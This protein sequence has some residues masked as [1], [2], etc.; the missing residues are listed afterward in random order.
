M[1]IWVSVPQGASSLTDSHFSDWQ[2]VFDFIESLDRDEDG[3]SYWRITVAGQ[4][5][6]DRLGGIH[7]VMWD[8]L[9]E[10]AYALKL[11]CGMTV[12][13]AVDRYPLKRSPA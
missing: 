10:N 8:A 12:G 9:A 4:V 7:D 2:S 11:L 1:S 3:V 6:E 5:V 13:V